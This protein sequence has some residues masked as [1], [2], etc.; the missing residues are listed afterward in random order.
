MQKKQKHTGR[1]VGLGI[2]AAIVLTLGIL[3]LIDYSHYA[4]DKSP[5]RTFIVPRLEIS[6]FQITTM[7][8]DKADMV[9]K[10]LIHNPLPFNLRADSLQYKIFI[11]GVEVIKS[12][13]AKSVLIRRWDSSWLNL[14]VTAYNDK[15]LTVLKQAEN[16]G[17]DS[18]IYEVQTSFGTNVIGHKD[19]NLDIQKLLPLIYIPEV[20]MNEIVYDSLSVKGVDLYLHT[21]IVN[22]N[23]FAFKFKNMAFRFALA[24]ENWVK[25]T[26]GGIIEIPDTSITALTLP[27]KISFS[28]M[29][30]SIGPLI[31]HGKNTPYKFEATLELVSDARALEN[32]KVVLKNAGAIKEITS[33][34][35]EEKQKAKEK[36]AAGE[37]PPKEKKHKLKIVK[38]TH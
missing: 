28:N 11:G 38:A 20:K 9:G 29:A 33:L 21:E 36:K 31:K 10:I 2:L 12:T 24:D 37:A 23:K 8:A 27:L 34:V 17:K 32:S 4:R 7:S 13:Y 30:K 35:K 22:K 16:E 3:F 19:F 26:L 14:P 1:Y 5:Y 18:I 6:V 15:L 25:G